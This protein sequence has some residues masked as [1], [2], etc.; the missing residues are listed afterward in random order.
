MSLGCRPQYLD[1]YRTEERSG[2]T[3]A[4]ECHRII[5]NVIDPAIGNIR[6]GEATPG[7]RNG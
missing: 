2:A 1:R 5:E 6:L 7:A 3:T 4:E